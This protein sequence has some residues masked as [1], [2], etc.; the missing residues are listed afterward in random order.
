MTKPANKIA[1]IPDSSIASAN[2]YGEYINMNINAIS[3]DGVL[4]MSIYLNN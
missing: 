2:T 3:N 1:I 4:R